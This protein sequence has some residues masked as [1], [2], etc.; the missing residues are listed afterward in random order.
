MCANPN[1]RTAALFRSC[2]SRTAWTATA[3]V[4]YCD[5]PQPPMSCTAMYR[6][7]PCPVLRFTATAH[8]MYCKCTATANVLY[9]D[10]SQAALSCTA[11]YLICPCPVLQCTATA[12]VMYCNVLPPAVPTAPH[13]STC[14]MLSPVLPLIT[15]P[16]SCQVLYCP[17]S[18]YLPHAKSCTASNNNVTKGIHRGP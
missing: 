14:T 15:L 5:V 10:V 6:N 13:H 17:S 18:L 9:C 7:R 16:A 12:C 1:R 4:L 3:H 11:M 2:P 8:V